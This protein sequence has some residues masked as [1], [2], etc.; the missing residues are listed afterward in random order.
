MTEQDL[1]KLSPELLRQCGKYIFERWLEATDRD[2]FRTFVSERPVDPDD[3]EHY[4]LGIVIGMLSCVEI[5][6]FSVEISEPTLTQQAADYGRQQLLIEQRAL[7]R[8]LTE[9]KYQDNSA[10]RT[11]RRL[12]DVIYLITMLDAIAAGDVVFP[13]SYFRTIYNAL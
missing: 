4:Q 10:T 6:G 13:N 7:E 2:F 5:F 8:A 3:R 9:R 11:A 1:Q 12:G